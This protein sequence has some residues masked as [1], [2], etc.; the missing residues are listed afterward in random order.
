MWSFHFVRRGRER[1]A[2]AASRGERERIHGACSGGGTGNVDAASVFRDDG[3][4]D[5]GSIASER[6]GDVAFGNAVGREPH[7]RVGGTEHRCSDKLEFLQR[8]TQDWNYLSL[9][10]L[11]MRVLELVTKYR[12]TYTEPA[13]NPKW[14]AS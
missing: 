5:S 11:L 8:H 9:A 2:G 3:V 6:L 4:G 14:N 10:S 12:P 1:G 13:R 7:F